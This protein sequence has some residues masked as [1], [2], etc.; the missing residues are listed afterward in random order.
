MN[1]VVFPVDHDKPGLFLCKCKGFG[2]FDGE[3]RIVR[4]YEQC[5]R[6]ESGTWLSSRHLDP[7]FTGHVVDV[8][9]DISW[10]TVLR[11][12]LVIAPS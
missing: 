9:E 7:L 11:S 5:N 6:W 12:M 10:T 1:D 2:P 8:V 3:I 4:N